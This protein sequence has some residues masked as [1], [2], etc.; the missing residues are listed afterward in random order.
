MLLASL[1]FSQG[2][3]FGFFTQ[4]L[5]VLLREDGVS[6][7]RIGLSGLLFLPWALKWVWAPWVDGYGLRKQWIVPLQIATILT[8]VALA[9]ADGS[10]F[11]LKLAIVLT[12]LFA[13][14]QDVPSD[15]LAVNLL[16]PHERGLGNAVQVG[17]YR[18]GM[19][20]GGGVLLIVLDHLGW[21]AAFLAMAAFLALT[22][23]PILH[24]DE[25]RLLPPATKRLLWTN[26]FKG[27]WARL[28][29]PGMAALLL[30]LIAYKFGDAM[31]SAMVKPYLVDQGWSKTAI[32]TWAGVVGST[33]G[34]LGAVLGGLLCDRLGRRRALLF[35]GMTQTL[36]VALYAL[37]AY[38]VDGD[39]LLKAAVALE[40]L[41][42][43]M[44]TVALFTLMMD[45]SDPD[46]AATDYTLQACVVVIASGIAGA[47]AGV[48][49]EALG[50]AALFALS[51]LA[52]A[53]GCGLLLWALAAGRVPPRLVGA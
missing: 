8:A 45:A 42:G 2:L 12:A 33:G 32:G 49:G 16:K 39:V 14:T 43:G 47:V 22:L 37:H 27:I 10:L 34:L 51:T 38:S 15:A 9:G 29:L 20:I 50:Y 35:C 5:P 21:A 31:T 11:W 48:M 4:A 6:L 44:A 53:L 26:P 24:F 17:G 25:A 52:S 30:W 3:P 13:A 1:Y 41:F 46:H 7:S 28:K 40:H 19:V 23:L 36:A 18:L